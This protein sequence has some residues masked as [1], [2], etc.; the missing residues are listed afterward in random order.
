M[1]CF[2][3]AAVLSSGDKL[4]SRWGLHLVIPAAIFMKELHVLTAFVD[5]EI[6]PKEDALNVSSITC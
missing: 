2:S 4:S 3:S 1:P 5:R 6:S